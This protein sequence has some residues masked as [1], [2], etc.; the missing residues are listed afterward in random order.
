MIPVVHGALH[1][2]L[3]WGQ[4]WSQYGDRRLVMSR[5]VYVAFGLIDHMNEKLIIISGALLLIASFALLLPL[6]RAYLAK[7]LTFLPVFIL[8]MIWFSLA[9][10]QNSLW[11]FQ[12]AWYLTTFFL[13]SMI[14]FLLRRPCNPSLCVAI[15]IAAAIAGSLSDIVGFTLWPIGLICV[16]WRSPW[17]R[18][19]YYEIGIWISAAL[20]A[21]A[22]YFHGYR[23]ATTLCIPA[24]ACSLTFGPSHPVLLA[25]FFFLIVGNV[26]PTAAS[27]AQYNWAAPYQPHALGAHQLLGVIICIAGAYV[28][29]QM[30]RERRWQMSPL[31][32]VLIVFAVLFDLDIALARVGQGLLSAV[33]YGDRYALPN[34]VMIV[35]IAVYGWSRII[36]ERPGESRSSIDRRRLLRG[37][38]ICVLSALVAAQLGLTTYFGVIEGSI[39]QQ[40]RVVAA[41]IAVNLDQSPAGERP[42]YLGGYLINLLDQWRQFAIHDQLSVFQPGLDTQYK[43]AGLPRLAACSR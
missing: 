40:E 30:I 33:Q 23:S 5:L 6:F 13:M 1:G 24:S 43:A 14:F 21:V 27:K 26:V 10:V 7:R 17:G 38:G 37:L 42:C 31:P 25:K 3:S 11:G 35:G 8:S 18:R 32:L 39:S 15:A 36:S 16:I 20:I 41:R 22:I 9:D 19:T 4:L 29:V 34:V 12:I 2:H 28:V